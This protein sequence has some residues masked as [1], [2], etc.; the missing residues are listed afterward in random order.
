MSSLSTLLF[1]YWYSDQE[2]GFFNYNLG[3]DNERTVLYLNALRDSKHLITTPL[4][5]LAYSELRSNPTKD[6]IHKV[7]ELIQI[8][9]SFFL[10]YRSAHHNTA[11]IDSIYRKMLKDNFCFLKTNGEIDLNDIRKY[12]RD[13]LISKGI[14][15]KSSW[16]NMAVEIPIY[17]V[18]KPITRLLLLHCFHDTTPNNSAPGLDKLGRSN[19]SNMLRPDFFKHTIEH[20]APTRNSEGLWNIDL[21]SKQDVVHKIGNLTLLPSTE[22]SSI[23]NKIWEYKKLLYS[24]LSCNDSTEL[25][26]LISIGREKGMQFQQSTE[27]II[28]DSSFLPMLKSISQ[29]DNEWNSEFVTKRGKNMLEIAWA[30]IAPKLGF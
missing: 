10:L 24:I 16:I 4:I 25:D 15:D 27:T 13:S 9:G 7:S 2:S 17:N 19:I 22:N 6:N 5:G 18:S 23:G 3:D 28:K 1:D 14:R 26:N 8:I 29:Y 20:I 12:F 21:Y 30:N 11:G